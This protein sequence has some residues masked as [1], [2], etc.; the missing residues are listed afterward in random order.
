MFNFST[1]YGKATE[2]E[3]YGENKIIV[4]FNSGY[5]NMVSTRANELG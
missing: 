5:V 1:N 2:M 4:G 3:W